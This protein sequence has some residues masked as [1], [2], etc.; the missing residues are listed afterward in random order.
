MYGGASGVLYVG[1]L[2]YIL[3]PDNVT[4]ILCGHSCRTNICVFLFTIADK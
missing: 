2:L 1:L 3:V 4:L